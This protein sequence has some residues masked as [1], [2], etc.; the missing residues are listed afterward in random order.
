[1]GKNQ[2]GAK[3]QEQKDADRKVREREKQLRHQHTT[4]LLQLEHDYLTHNY[5]PLPVVIAEGDGVWVKDA[6]G[7]KYLDCLAGYSSLNF[8]HLNQRLINRAKEQMDNL[9][10]V[11]RAF[12]NAQLGPF[13]KALAELSQ[14]DMVLPMNTG[15]E[16]VETALKISRAWAY[17]VKG[18]P[19]DRANIITMDGNFHGR[20]TTIVSFSTDPVARNDFGP[21]TPGFRTATFGDA[22][23]VEALI[24]EDTAAVLV[25]PIQGEAGV[26]IP[27]KDFL[28]RVRELCDK[29]NVI[30]IADEIQSGLC[31][32]GYTFA[33]EMFDVKPDLMTLGKALGGG[34]VPLSAVVGKRRFMDVLHPGQHGSTFGGNP[35]AAAIGYEVCQMISE[36][37]WQK[38]AQER[39][40]QL[41]A[42]LDKLVG[43][44][45]TTYRAA[46][47][48]VGVDIDPDYGTGR[49]LCEHLAARGIL[50]K[51][52]HGHTVRLCPPLCISEDEIDMLAQTVA[53]CLEEMVD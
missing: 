53:Q 44:G 11:S 37:T 9:T 47:M 26:I 21:L 12:C 36:G 52:T 40:Q 43:R 5:H 39:S 28:K 20:T 19:A 17:R 27:P 13:A 31:R 38:A 29:H 3:A 46:G 14:M 45:L 4:E 30:M 42:H 1:M 48:W 2:E 50:A 49:D 24:D 8:G 10:M 6:D 41:T 32:T 18:V 34:I 22:D 35:L 15:A 25:E 23:S 51:D 16:A 33:C 7:R